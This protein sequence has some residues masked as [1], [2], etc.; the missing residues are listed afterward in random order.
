MAS[1]DIAVALTLVH[2]GG[3]EDNPADPGGATSM[4]IEQRDVP[5]IPIQTLTL[6]QATQYY[7]QSYWKPFYSQINDQP[8]ASKLFDLGVLFGVGTAVK[9]LQITLGVTVDEDFGPATLQALNEAPAGFLDR[10]KAAMWQHAQAIVT[11]TPS[12]LMFLT[13]WQRRIMS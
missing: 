1:F 9:F 5:S 3:F 4:G 10:Y 8:T 2:E 7:A 12:S 13:G 11:K 6:A